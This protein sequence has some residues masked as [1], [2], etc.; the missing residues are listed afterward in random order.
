MSE[1][2]DLEAADWWAGLVPVED[3]AQPVPG[4]KRA[5]LARLRRANDPLEVMM[6]PDALRLVQRLSTFRADS[7]RVVRVAVLA[8]VLAVVR[9]HVQD[10]IT[11]IL[12][13]PSLDN[14][15]AKLSE[16]RFR[17]ILQTPANDLLGPMRR[18]VRLANC[19]VNVPD[20]AKSILDWD[21]P[22]TKQRWIFDYYGASFAVVPPKA[23]SRTN[24]THGGDAL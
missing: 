12:G 20:L 8:G 2:D 11:S 5:A 14:E 16:G 17:R 1:R 15:T 7:D 21:E 23:E 24:Q 9:K 3:G 4:G 18:L 22:K 6:E 10:P 13:R 19:E